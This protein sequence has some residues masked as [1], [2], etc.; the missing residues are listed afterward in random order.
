MLVCNADIPDPRMK[1]ASFIHVN[2][3]VVFIYT[4]PQYLN[5]IGG[6]HHQHARACNPI[7]LFA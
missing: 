4:N 6:A 1:D 2:L 7:T 3:S 5:N